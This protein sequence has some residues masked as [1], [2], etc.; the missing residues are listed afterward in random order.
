MLLAFSPEQVEINFVNSEVGTGRELLSITSEVLA[1]ETGK[2]EMAADGEEGEPLSFPEAPLQ[3]GFN[4]RYLLEPLLA[5]KGEVVMLEVND[6]KRACRVICP[7]D[8]HYY[9]IIMPMDI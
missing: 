5:M 3:V 8:Q 4:T 9:G 7:L 2:V 1:S 6:P